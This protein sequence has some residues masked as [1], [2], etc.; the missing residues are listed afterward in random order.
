[1]SDQSANIIAV[2]DTNILVRLALAKTN[3]AK[4]LWQAAQAGQ[5]R[6]LVSE[7]ILA[8]LDRVL[9]YPRIRN[10]YN[11]TD[12]SIREFINSLRR[13]AFLTDDL[14]QV[15]R[16]QADESDNI[17]LA[18]ALEGAADYLVSEDPHLRDIKEYQNVQIIGITDFQSLTSNP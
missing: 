9:H 13:I 5:Y 16:V 1:M 12:T 2:F 4:Q 3:A 7:S 11:L 14:Y 17:F 10:R 6:L 18:C 8:E 15:S